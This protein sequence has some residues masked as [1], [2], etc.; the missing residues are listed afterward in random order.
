MKSLRANETIAYA[1]LGDFL[2]RE[3]LVSTRA[4]LT[5]RAEAQSW[6][7]SLTMALRLGDSL[8]DVTLT[9]AEAKYQNKPFIDFQKSPPKTL[10]IKWEEHQNL[11]RFGVALWRNHKVT[12][13]YAI[14]DYD[15]FLTFLD[16]SN[17]SV[18]DV[19]FVFAS[20]AQILE[21]HQNANRAE[22]TKRASTRLPEEHSCRTWQQSSSKVRF[23]LISF[24][25]FALVL[26]VVLFPSECLTVLVV[27][28]SL[29][30]F[31]SV[32]FKIA[33]FF[34]EVSARPNDRPPK[35]PP[36]KLPKFSV[37]VPLYKEAEIASSL[38]ARLS[39]LTYPKPLLEVMLAVEENDSTTINALKD[40]TLPPWMKT[41]VVPDGAPKTKPRAMNYALEFC[42]GEIIGVWDAEDDPASDQ[43]EV[44]ADHFHAATPDLACLQGVLDYYNS[45]QNWLARCFTIE[46][47]AWFRLILPGL[48]RLGFA[49][50]LGGTTLFVRKDALEKVGGWDAHN[51][52][53]DADLGFRLAK[54]GFTTEVVPTRT[55]EE[56]NCKL[57]PWVKQRSRWLKGYMVTYIVNMRRPASLFK[58]LGAWR[59]LGFQAHFVTALSQ[60]LLA[61]VL[62]SFWLVLLGLTHPL[63]AYVSRD[64]LYTLGLAFLAI[65][66]LNALIYATVCLK[67]GL[68][69]LLLW[70]PTM[71][72]YYPLGAIAAY[73]AVYE[74][75]VKPYYW[76]KTQ[77]GLSLTQNKTPGSK[78]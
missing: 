54:L 51:V 49:I 43:L 34:A 57:W 77:H 5:A 48:A 68:R 20:Q 12:P 70:V 56:A 69:H 72:I 66:V 37:I 29:T 33:A 23:I 28:A 16:Q 13:I 71:H 18:G 42:D 25:A 31:A 47:A 63:E 74:L 9:K 30:L 75:V 24:I 61:P 78:T 35:C 11:Q 67:P 53:E 38:V 41:I 55:E 17:L 21:W 2:L 62:W 32:L 7:V 64:V 76:D 60:F 40:T 73:K 52:T 8:D 65:E 10:A 1:D 50:P 45:R 46:Y 58:Q 3:G 22:L 4:L 59:F 26:G 27:W 19:D 15:R 39:T 44:I 14:S 6:N 36:D